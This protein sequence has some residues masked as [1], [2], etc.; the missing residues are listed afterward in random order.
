MKRKCIFLDRDG[1]LNK[2][3]GE[4]V[5]TLEKFEICTGI[6]DLLK[7]YQSTYLRIVITNQGGIAKGQYTHEDVKKCHA[8]FQD[9]SNYIIDYFYYSPYHSSVTSSLSS[10][11]GSL[12]F[13]KAIAKYNI[14]PAQSWMI[15]DK[16]RDILPA[17]KL[18]IQT[19]KLDLGENEL[20]TADYTIKNLEDISHVI[21]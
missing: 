2:E 6:I 7:K 13:E 1:V 10:K 3:I 17:K 5:Y 20:T 9:Q 8:Y 11:P 21:Q 4:Y 16:E 19:I 12:L 15:G 14:D 18:G